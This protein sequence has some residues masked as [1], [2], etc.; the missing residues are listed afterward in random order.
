[1][2][3]EPGRLLHCGTCGLRGGRDVLAATSDV[4]IVRA[5]ARGLDRPAHLCGPPDHMA[6]FEVSDTSL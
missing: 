4:A 6:L 3:E 1:L 5:H 2:V